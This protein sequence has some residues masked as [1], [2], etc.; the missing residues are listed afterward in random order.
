[1]VLHADA[2]AP[3]SWRRER[4]ARLLDVSEGNCG[5]ILRRLGGF[6]AAGKLSSL[7]PP[8]PGMER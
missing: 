2:L 6:I 8:V 4:F 7:T 3:S 5:K 1:M